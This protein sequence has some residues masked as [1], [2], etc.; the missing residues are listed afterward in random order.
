MQRY[1]LFLVVVASLFLISAPNASAN[2]FDFE[3]SD[4]VNEEGYNRQ[5]SHKILHGLKNTMIGFVEIGS[6]PYEAVQSGR[7][8]WVG[9]GEGLF[10][11]IFDTV[12]GVLT[13]ATFPITGLD[14]WM[15]EGGTDLGEWPESEK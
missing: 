12:G 3:P 1:L 5:M 15:P 10:N 6:E 13:L 14:I 7:P 2:A 4:W 9:V 8:F 11:G